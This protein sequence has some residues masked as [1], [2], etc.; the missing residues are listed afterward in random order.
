MRGGCQGPGVRAATTVDAAAGQL[1]ARSHLAASNDPAD[2]E[3]VPYVLSAELHEKRSDASGPTI[4]L[5]MDGHPG[6][7]DDDDVLLADEGPQ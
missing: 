4:S 5:V 3:E 2:E 7:I 1:N 6:R